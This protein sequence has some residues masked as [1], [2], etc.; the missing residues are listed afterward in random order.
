MA[1]ARPGAVIDNGPLIREID[2]APFRMTVS[3]DRYC[4]PDY[5]ARE[6]ERLWMH[7]WQVA[8]RPEELPEAGDWKEYTLFDQSWILVRGKD[9]KI[10]GF[11]NAC[12]HRGNA[13]CKGRGR[14]AR[15]TC[16]YHNW[17]YGLDGALLAVA[18]PDFD[19]TIEQFVGDKDQLGLLEIPVA[20]F[21]GFIFL[22]PD[23]AAEPLLSYLGEVAD[24]LA[25]YK[26]DEMVPVALNVR[27]AIDC[28]WKVI[29]DAFEEGY[30]IQGV[31]PELIPAMDESKERY[32]FFGDHSVATGPFGASNMVDL[33]PEE[34][35]EVIRALPNTFPAVAQALPRFEELVNATRDAAGALQF[36]TQ[37]GVRQ[38]LQ[39]ATRETWSAQGLDVSG[40]TDTQMSDNHFHTVFPN[41]FMTI[42][43]G[44]CT[45]II[46]WPH[47]DGDPNRCVWHVI[48]LMWLPE[49]QRR[50]AIEPCLE[51][52][53]GDHFTYF[54]P[55]EQDWEQMQHQQRG[56]R[57][58][59]LKQT[60]L[61]R[62]EVRLAHYHAVLDAWLERGRSR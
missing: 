28:N 59:A 18:R 34:Q 1:D 50:A 45:T 62:Q 44:E 25:P 21:A 24:L 2:F 39:Q 51:I 9:E 53:E 56:L 17:T 58:R 10:R 16:P 57:N 13:F 43:A 32:G 49:D 20:V 27:E 36:T 14:A 12:R 4:D 30:H 29:M 40:L 8:G 31:H 47:P 33:S 61:T 42:R 5:H 35:V 54:L 15:F 46:S 60:V 41:L 7:C 3:T 38:L 52:A 26:L 23:P 6:R 55:L 11:V 37:T 19:G 48:N 22:N